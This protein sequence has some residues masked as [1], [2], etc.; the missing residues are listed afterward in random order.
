M[1]DYNTVSS[2]MKTVTKRYKMNELAAK[3]GPLSVIHT[4]LPFKMEIAVGTND[5]L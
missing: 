3:R 4:Q 2:F 5:F 1:I